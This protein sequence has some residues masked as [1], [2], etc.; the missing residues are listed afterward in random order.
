MDGS[1]VTIIAAKGEKNV[2]FV[3]RKGYRA[4]NT[5]SACGFSLLHDAYVWRTTWLR[6]R[7][8]EG[9]VAKAYEQL[10][11]QEV[12]ASGV[13]ESSPET[14]AQQPPDAGCLRVVQAQVWMP[15]NYSAEMDASLETMP[16]PILTL[17]AKTC[18][19]GLSRQSGERRVLLG[20]QSPE[21]VVCNEDQDHVVKQLGEVESND[22]GVGCGVEVKRE[23]CPDQ[24]CPL[25][26]PT[27]VC[28][29]KHF[30]PPQAPRI[31]PRTLVEHLVY[32]PE[33]VKLP[34]TWNYHK[35]R[36]PRG[37]RVVYCTLAV[38]SDG[39]TPV[40]SKFVN[41]TDSSRGER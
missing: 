22:V 40:I 10:L 20:V 37:N 13:P 9:Y 32:H 16:C 7:F 4:L 18:S 26:V 5:M 30:Y 6:R 11:G 41:I 23:E 35:V 39:M 12:G 31:V 19:T 2:A 14:V 17:T 15:R 24:Q 3:C 21:E 36:A 38:A 25:Q 33:V 29:G 27:I 1:L 34:L 8:Q 28:V